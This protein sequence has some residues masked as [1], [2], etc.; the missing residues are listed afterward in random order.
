MKMVAMRRPVSQKYL[1]VVAT[2]YIGLL[3]P[4]VVIILKEESPPNKFLF[5]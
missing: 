2:I 3:L 5:W 4:V 1:I